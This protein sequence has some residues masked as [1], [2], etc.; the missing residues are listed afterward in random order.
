MKKVLFIA[1]ISVV[2][3]ASCSKERKLN[4]KLDGTWNAVSYDGQAMAAGQTITIAFDKDKK[5]NGTY[6]MT[7]TYGGFSSVETGTYQL[8]KDDLITLTSAGD[9]DIMTVTDYSK[10]DLTITDGGD[11]IILKKQ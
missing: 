2:A 1:I 10:T 11:V 4:K 7:S 6:T 9:V 3:L 5:D 8:T